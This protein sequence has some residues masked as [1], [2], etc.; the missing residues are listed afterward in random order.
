[1]S[2]VVLCEC[3]AR[4][5]LQHESAVLPTELKRQLLEGLAGVGFARI[6]ATSYA[7]PAVIP[8][9]ADAS[10]LLASLPRRE[11]VSYKATCPNPRAVAR[12]LADRA[13][14]CGVDEISVLVSASDSHSQRNLG[15]SRIEQWR[16]IDEMIAAARDRFRI[17]GS[18]SVAFGCPFEGRVDPDDVLAD[19]Q[20]FVQ[21]GVT[22]VSLGDT[23]GL[24][25]PRTVRSMC[26]RVGRECPDATVV[27]HFH[28]TRGTGLANYVA[29]LEAGVRHFD[30][31]IGGVGGHPTAI[32]Y[33]AGHTG[34]VC[35]ED[36]VV[37]LEAMGVA[38]GID[39][40]RLVDVARACEA[41]L[42][43]RLSSRVLRSGW[44]T[45]AAVPGTAG[46]PG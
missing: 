13:K 9:F 12:A 26:E 22:L 44:Q 33:G 2:D 45:R 16:L 14:G 18:I 20:R 38:T 31:A 17:I 30:C 43:R 11:G 3:F 34:N 7:N 23:V 28:D 5:G 25:T 15:R 10:E 21:Q 8:Q 32:P 24:A 40:E 19:V 39:I 42:G 27:A 41:A 37:L 46:A 6:E 29:A 4:D 1:M 35:T 36:W